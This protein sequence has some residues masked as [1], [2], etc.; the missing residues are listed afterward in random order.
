[1]A[2]VVYQLRAHIKRGRSYVHS[3]QAFVERTDATNEIPN[4]QKEQAISLGVTT[5]KVVVDLIELQ[6]T[7]NPK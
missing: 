6:L 7:G 5:E 1:M 3:K 4:F 2:T